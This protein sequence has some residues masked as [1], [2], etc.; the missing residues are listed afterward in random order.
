MSGETIINVLRGK[1]PCEAFLANIKTHDPLLLRHM[2]HGEKDL[3]TFG[4]AKDPNLA[5]ASTLTKRVYLGKCTFVR[6]SIE[7]V[8]L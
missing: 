4:H 5:T 6:S 3:W 7:M 2:T 1:Y 8:V